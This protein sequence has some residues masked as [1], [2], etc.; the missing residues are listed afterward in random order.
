MLNEYENVAG[1]KVL[2]SGPGVLA[3][4]HRGP[5]VRA[6]VLDPYIPSPKQI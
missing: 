4:E 3:L 2:V 5:A 1:N 6:R